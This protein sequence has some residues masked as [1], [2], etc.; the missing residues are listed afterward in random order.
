MMG[1]FSRLRKIYSRDKEP[2]EV[3]GLGGALLIECVSFASIPG[4]LTLVL[5]PSTTELL[6]HRLHTFEISESGKA[7]AIFLSSTAMALQAYKY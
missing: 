5:F 7:G 2:E 4:P 1:D 3:R 6:H